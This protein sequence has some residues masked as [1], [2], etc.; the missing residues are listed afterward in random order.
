MKLS[1][2]WLEVLIEQSLSQNLAAS[3]L[4]LLLRITNMAIRVM[5][6]CDSSLVQYQIREDVHRSFWHIVRLRL[7]GF[8]NT[9]ESDINKTYSLTVCCLFQEAKWPC[10]SCPVYHDILFTVL[11]RLLSF[12]V[13]LSLRKVEFLFQLKWTFARYNITWSGGVRSNCSSLQFEITNRL[14]HFPLELVNFEN[15]NCCLLST[16]RD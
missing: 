1:V 8:L 14:V 5:I 13:H 2:P 11:A 12:G 9:G 15:D 7:K 4:F 3:I 10:V 16:A 6:R